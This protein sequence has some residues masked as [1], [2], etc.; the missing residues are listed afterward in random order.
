MLLALVDVAGMTEREKKVSLDALNA[1]EMEE[2][3]KYPS[4]P[5]RK[6]LSNHASH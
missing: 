3:R 4:H 6:E 5:P 1:A 2:C